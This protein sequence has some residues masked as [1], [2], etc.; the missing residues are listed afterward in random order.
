MGVMTALLRRCYI[1]WHEALLR[2]CYIGWLE[3]EVGQLTLELKLVGVMTAVTSLLHL[4]AGGA[5]TSLLH[6]LVRGRIGAAVLDLDM[7]IDPPIRRHRVPRVPCG[8]HLKA[9]HT[10]SCSI[11]ARLGAGTGRRAGRH[12]RATVRWARRTRPCH[13]RPCA[14]GPPDSDLRCPVRARRKPP[15]NVTSRL[16]GDDVT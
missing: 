2:P 10:G 3:V 4:L 16:R 12:L 14:S 7:R 9:P 1:C 15:P 6:W 8:V 13:T 11:P 5:V